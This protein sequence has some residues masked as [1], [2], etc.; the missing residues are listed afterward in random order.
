MGDQT[1][2]P[3]DRS[4]RLGNE[5]RHT[6]DWTEDTQVSPITF[7]VSAGVGVGSLPRVQAQRGDGLSLLDTQKPGS[8]LLGQT[9]LKIR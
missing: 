1:N 7:S 6:V 3:G 2:S 5:E 9:R 4:H 8:F